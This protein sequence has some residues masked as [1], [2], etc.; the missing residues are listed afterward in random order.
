MYLGIYINS[1][2]S[3]C[4][5]SQK[6]VCIRPAC[7]GSSLPV[8]YVGDP[9]F[10]LANDIFIC[11]DNCQV[12]IPWRRVTPDIASASGTEDSVSNPASLAAPGY[13]FFRGNI[14]MLLR[15]HN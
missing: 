10:N 8:E 12:C 9:G 1:K 11:I 13:K 4:Q 5:P 6:L 15:L 2:K 14:A 3:F 7:K